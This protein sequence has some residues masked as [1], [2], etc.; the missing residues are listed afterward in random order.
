MMK[1][2]F[3][4]CLMCAAL[5]IAVSQNA[6][7][8]YININ[9]ATPN[10]HPLTV[11]QTSTG[12][13]NNNGSG[14]IT[15]V[16][17]NTNPF[18]AVFDTLKYYFTSGQTANYQ[19]WYSATSLSGNNGGAAV[20]APAWTQAMNASVAIT[21]NQMNVV[22][23]GIGL[24][25]PPNTRYRF[26][27]IGAQV[28]YITAGASTN[29]DSFYNSGIG[30]M[31]G[32][33]QINGQNVGYGQATFGFTPRG[34]HGEVGLNLLSTPCTGTP[35]AGTPTGDSV[36][37]PGAAQGY[38]L[39]GTSPN[40]GLTY[41]WIS[42]ATS[43]GP[44]TIIPGATNATYGFIPP[45]GVQTCLR[46]IVTCTASAGFDTS[47]A[48]CINPQLWSP[49]SPCYCTSAATSTFSEEG[50]GQVT[51]AATINPNPAEPKFNNPLAALTYSDYDTLTPIATVIKGQSYPLGV[52]QTQ[53]GTFMSNA[54]TAFYIDY[55]HDYF[56]ASD[57]V[58]DTA[59]LSTTTPPGSAATTFTVPVTALTGVTR[60]RFIL[61]EF[62]NATTTTVCAPYVDGETE[63][64]LINI[65]DASP[66]DPA[67]VSITP[68]TNPACLDSNEFVPFT[69]TNFGSLPLDLSIDTLVVRLRV[70]GPNGTQL[71][72]QTI[73]AGV[74][75]PYNGNTLGSFFNPVDF[76]TGGTYSVN[77]DSMYLLGPGTNGFLGNDSLFNPLTVVNRRPNA[78]PDTT[79]LCAGDLFP[80]AGLD[81]INCP[82]GIQTDSVI[83]PFNIA[84]PSNLPF[85]CNAQS[86]NIF[87]S[88]V[89][90]ALPAGANVLNAEVSVTN[91]QSAGFLNFPFYARFSI[92]D[93]TAALNPIPAVDIFHPGAAGTASASTFACF[94]YLDFPTAGNMNN[95]VTIIPVGGPINMGYWPDAGVC[96]AMGI[97]TN[98][99]AMGSVATLK[100]VY[101][102]VPVGI[103]WYDQ[104][105]G[106]AN[107]SQASPLDPTA[108]TN[109]VMNN[110]NLPGTYTFFGACDADSNCR[111][112]LTVIVSEPVF[113]SV[114]S[115]NVLCFGDTTGTISV[116]AVDPT[117][118]F[119]IVPAATQLTSGNFTGLSA[120]VAYTVTLQ[121]PSGCTSDSIVTLIGPPSA[122]TLSIDSIKDVGCF[123]D[124]NGVAI[125]SATGGTGTPAS[126]TY[127]INPLPTSMM[128]S[129]SGTFTGLTANAMYT[130]YA[131]D[132]VGCQDSI[133]FAI[134]QPVLLDLVFDSLQN[135]S[136]NAAMDGAIYT[137]T[138]GGTPGF[139]YSIFPLGGTQVAPGDFTG[140]GPG[141]YTITVVDTNGCTDTVNATII[142]PAPL[143]IALDSVQDA[144]CFGDCNGII[145]TSSTGGNAGISYSINTVPAITNTT[146]TFAGLCAGTYLVTVTDTNGCVDTIS[147]IIAEPNVLDIAIDSTLDV[148]CNGVCDGAIF[149]TTSGGTLGYSF[150]I[151]TVPAQSNLTGDFIGLCAGTYLITVTDTNGCIDTISATVIQPSVLDLVVDSTNNASCNGVCDGEIFTSSTGG[152]AGINYSINTVP[153]QTNTTGDFTALCAGS[154]IVTATDT[155]GCFD[156]VNVD[157][158]EPAVLVIAIDSVSDETCNGSM[159]G[160]I[161]A[162][163]TGGNAGQVFDINAVPAIPSN[164][165]GT[166]TGLAAGTYLV[167]VTDTNGCFDTISATII[168]PASLVLTV[169]STSDVSCFGANDG[170]IY[171]SFVGGNPNYNYYLN[172]VLTPTS[173][174]GTFT[175]LAP[176]LYDVEIRDTNNCT[177]SVLAILISE[178]PVLNIDSIISTTPSCVPG[179]DATITVY[180]S[181][182]NSGTM[183]VN[184]GVTPPDT[185]A[186]GIFMNVGAG[187]YPI[188]V[189]DANGCFDTLTHIISIPNAPSFTSV[190]ADSVLCFGDSN[191]SVTLVATGGSGQ[192]QYFI[193]T[194]PPDSNFTGIFNNLGAGPYTVSVKD[195]NNCEVTSPVTVGEPN[196]LIVA[197]DSTT[198]ETCNGAGDGVIYASAMGGTLG[199]SYSISTSAVVNT[200]GTFTGLSAGPHLITVTDTNGCVDTITATIIAPAS[201]V[202][203]VDSTSDVSCFGANDGIIYTSFV[204]GNPTYN[205]YLNN[206]LTPTSPTGTFTGLAPGLYDVEIRD[207]N[208]CTSSVL[209][210]LISEPPVLNIDSI[211][212]TTPSCVP[213][214]DAAITVYASGGNSGTMYVNNGVTPPDTNATGIFMN[215]G[216]GTYPI[217]VFDVNGCFDTLTHIIS[218]PNAPSFTSIVADS[219]L[220]FGDSNGTVT[221]MATG[222]SGQL[223]YFINTTPPDSNFTGIFNNLGAG[224]YTVSVKDTNNCE[225]TSPVTV[226]E[227]NQLIVAIDSTLDETCNGAGDG[228][229]Y[230]SAMGGTLGYSYSIST[231]AVV[232]TTGT[233]TGL[234]AGPHLITV[235]DTN[236]CVDT[237]TAIVNSPAA[238]VLSLD[239]SDNVSCNGAN[240]GT[241]YMSHTGGATGFSYSINTIPPDTNTTGTFTGLPPG[242][243]DV[244]IVDTNGC[245]DVVTGIVITEPAVLM[246]DSVVSTTPSCVPGDDATI[247]VYAS[248]GNGGTMYVNNGVAP[249]DTNMTG[250]FM[251]VG[252]GSFP[253]LVFDANG[254]FDTLTHV[255]SIPNAPSIT[256][257]T[258]VDV[259]CNGDSSGSVT[260]V[261]TGGTGGLDYFINTVPPDTNATGLFNNLPAGPFTI[262]VIDQN[263]CS[264]TQV[265]NINE[266]DSITFTMPTI[267]N[268]LCNGDSSG[269]INITSIGGAGGTYTYSINAVPPIPSNTTGTFMNLPAGMYT[270]TST[271]SFSC[272]GDTM[273][274]I[275]EPPLLSI[276]GTTNSNV[277]CNGGN[278]GSIIVNHTGGVPGYSYSINGSAPQTSPTFG[279]LIAG[280]YNVIVT[281]TNGCQDSVLGI[282]ITEPTLL[283]IDSITST[284]PS[285]NPGG[286]ATLTTW[287]SGGTPGYT[288]SINTMP[289]MTN[290][291]GFFSN[292][293]AG[294]YLITLTDTNGC[295]DT[296]SYEIVTPNAPT[297]TSTSSTNVIC[298][299]DS[300]GTISTL[301]GGGTGTIIYSLAPANN[302]QVGP[303]PG[304]N[305][306]NV[307][308]D[309]YVVTAT[310]A[311]GC[312]VT[313]SFTITEPN[314]F[315]FNVVS[316]TNVS[317]FGFN[318]G[319][320]IVTVVGGT[321]VINLTVAPAVTQLPALSGNLSG[322]SAGPH[323]ITATDAAGCTDTF[324]LIIT[325]PT[326]V[327]FDTSA[328]T[329]VSCAGL[330][331]GTIFVGAS[332][333]TGQIDYIVSTMPP[334]TNSTGIFTGLPAANP[335][336]VT[337]IDANGCTSTISIV[338]TEPMPLSGSGSSTDVICNG[339]T[340]GTITVVPM[341]GTG[342]TFSYTI[343]TVPT[344]TNTT[345][346]FTGLAA[347]SPGY[348]V[349]IS[350]VNGCT[351]AV[352]PIQVSEPPAVVF[353]NVSVQDVACFGDSTGSISVN[354]I[355]G[356]GSI[357]Y[358]ISPQVGTQNI[359]LFEQL[360][361]GFYIITAEDA[362]GCLVD[363]TVFV[364]QNPQIIFT[365]IVGTEP[366]C[367]YDE[368]G[369]I[370]VT[371]S[372]G[373][374]NLEYNFEFGP[375]GP[376]TTW[377]NL[378]I[379]CYTIGV[380]DALGCTVDTVYCLPGP[381]PI[382][383]SSIDLRNTTCVDSDDG[384]LT[385]V[386]TGGRGS[387][388][389]YSLMP[390]F[391][392]NT[393]GIF[394]ELA[395]GTYTLLVTD[396]ARCMWDTTIVIGLPV[397]PLVTSI[398]K[399]DLDC[400]GSGS[401][402]FAEVIANGGLP[403][404][405]Y[406][407]N[408][409]PQQTSA[410]VT[411][412]YYGWY[413][414][415]VT[416]ANGCLIKDTIYIE[417]GP[418][419][420]EV[421]IPTA[422]SPNGDGRNDEYRLRSNAGIELQQ[423][424]INNRWGERVFTTTDYTQT[425]DGRYKGDEAPT[426][427]YY[428]IFRYKCLTDGIEYTIGGDVTLIR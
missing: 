421:F 156:T 336:T 22:F 117:A 410:Q 414:V 287:F 407:W 343:N 289:V 92:F 317:C 130:I 76:Y 57:Y 364:D 322:M 276:T 25:I 392:V 153:P 347:N 62:G 413:Q 326:A 420:Q 114:A 166:F 146:G 18:P 190:V 426:G 100:L 112:P 149:T 346:L 323:L 340:T 284:L 107:F 418:C 142:E 40:S 2:L 53:L 35:V 59:L 52:E 316:Q 151:N 274:N 105:V 61:N 96:T 248:G 133:T 47:S 204:G 372:G 241:I 5:T 367:S 192:L 154:Y 126:F 257:V 301:A 416:D 209:A 417:P 428:Y 181:G 329:N 235:T 222:G 390:G 185:N 106:G 32:D 337:A 379:D 213:G 370:T 83:I 203:T 296:M 56:G 86:A 75:L 400:I 12:Y 201:L 91:L 172:N 224:P 79:L 208:N 314:P 363:T 168:A 131:T 391:N 51:M 275:T 318:D 73:S 260:I 325:E 333:G 373:I 309:N 280:S 101:E 77:I 29:P 245:T 81:I 262:G 6:N 231:S 348:T 205:Y 50:I 258:T 27:L 263:S 134:T 386:A 350:D 160:I 221:L 306:T 223:Q 278:D 111:V 229:I 308:P 294:M 375:F 394:R 158:L 159:D 387:V 234:S 338:I 246:I 396:T 102:Y 37:C 358:S 312:F 295:V 282:V 118:T 4:L 43:A 177:S 138:N 63:D 141:M 424:E 285:C 34:F 165:T 24:S 332:G 191:G 393:S 265:I 259:L 163:A 293:S 380:R 140:L 30:L 381:D 335:Y 291:T 328:S 65:I 10:V 215:V 365:S 200:T 249:P 228:V 273:I 307:P 378:G 66:L 14:A 353:N 253:I 38:G 120:G 45:P 90:P 8:Q 230:A 427:T 19:L 342:P 179:N 398:T 217:L 292:L 127:T 206:V 84:V 266:P 186:T 93:G 74:L 252:A 344:V 277:L 286:D 78:F 395:P 11:P 236:G 176:G 402:G 310:D 279:S 42:A 82:T 20:A 110:T 175:G 178:P 281:D 58:W 13:F 17:N 69:F 94:D 137:T 272:I 302:A 67:V 116:T 44:W 143:V 345:G 167:T 128:Q 46:C 124:S 220:C 405:T 404:Y 199:Y 334:D 412:L 219:V 89:M 315:V 115:T 210:I 385:V 237:I 161:Y 218:I 360:P 99:G 359:G 184:N 242:T 87:A 368:N 239:S 303:G 264:S 422:F 104:A 123:G 331:D 21:A 103:K 389:T 411:G 377:N 152:N 147:G 33:Y 97:S 150:G 351:A 270:I 243:Y 121:L 320:A 290:T 227:P 247:T 162:S 174:T 129:P 72:T 300:T 23:G 171:T 268:V 269:S 250:I 419:C 207:T 233:F 41:Q 39:I 16:I 305:W 354:A 376:T 139:N 119:S 313:T 408:T 132:S 36:P 188:L 399:T 148:S 383:L 371:A 64:Y 122:F 304:G 1:K 157:I 54:H 173:P 98:C 9:T 48:I 352:G 60:A 288:I 169:D 356:V 196:Q 261:G 194:T 244:T 109:P 361:S 198:D 397:N 341:G 283:S 319:A 28:R 95:M 349:I 113:A 3:N 297:W 182:G 189:Y 425:W 311:V 195:T 214:N 31:N 357:S 327:T 55:N 406:L 211:I 254:C 362:N 183:Y 7:A 355:G 415:D 401:E 225:V 240:D 212:S 339:D 193:N 403:P 409:T 330:S 136:C 26:Q 49:T 374:G 80:A 256:S 299:G 15:F 388:Y 164:T 384:R 226:G 423:F 170:I 382:S 324:T 135:V 180:A 187:T 366:I 238:I 255:I 155:N 321:G 251:N 232:N 125:V 271:D 108:V 85:N 202:L 144:L 88:G 298:N 197:I 71:Y 68:P 145:Y 369:S 267:N 216:A 70:S